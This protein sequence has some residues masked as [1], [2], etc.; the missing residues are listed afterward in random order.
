MRQFGVA[1][2][3]SMRDEQPDKIGA[4]RFYSPDIGAVPRDCMLNFATINSSRQ[5]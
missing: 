5:N 3:I 2:P 4:G 1:T